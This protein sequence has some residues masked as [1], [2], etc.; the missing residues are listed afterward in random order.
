MKEILAE[1]AQSSQ[2]IH[3]IV[4]KVQVLDIVNDLFQAGHNGIAAFIGILPKEH[5]KDNCFIFL[6]LKVPLHHCELVKIG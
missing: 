6:C 1:D 3:I 2:I 4:G 5:V